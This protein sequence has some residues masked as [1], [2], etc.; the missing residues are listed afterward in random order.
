MYQSVAHNDKEITG[1]RALLA[2]CFSV[3]MDYVF[4][5]FLLYCPIIPLCKEAYFNQMDHIFTCFSK[6]KPS[7]HRGSFYG[8]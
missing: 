8:I 5:R 7:V 3:V 1:Q 6:T 4:N 2:S